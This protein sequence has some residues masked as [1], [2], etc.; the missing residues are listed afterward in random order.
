MLVDIAA[1]DVSKSIFIARGFSLGARITTARHVERHLGRDQAGVAERDRLGVAE[2][3][4][5][6]P[7]VT[8]VDAEPAFAARRVYAQH[9]AALHRVPDQKGGRLRLHLADEKLGEL[10]PAGGFFAAF[11]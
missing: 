5:T 7:T 8:A 10:S 3:E 2:P 9:Q 1:G 4:P 11:H 6:R